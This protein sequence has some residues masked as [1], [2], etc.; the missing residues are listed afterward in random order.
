[1][2]ALS[3]PSEV[4]PLITSVI[5]RVIDTYSGFTSG[6]WLIVRQIL[7]MFFQG[8]RTKVSLFLTNGCQNTDG[9]F[10]LDTS[11]LPYG[12]E[13]PGIVRYYESNQIKS[14][15]HSTHINMTST[16]LSSLYDISSELGQSVYMKGQLCLFGSHQPVSD[17]IQDWRESLG[18]SVERAANRILPIL[19]GN[20]GNV[21]KRD[22]SAEKGK[23]KHENLNSS[24]K[25][26]MFEMDASDEKIG[27]QIIIV[28]QSNHYKNILDEFDDNKEDYYGQDDGHN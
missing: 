1:M 7:Y 11:V 21:A 27:I 16:P 19:A 12:T 28:D 13:N 10:L 25:L 26:D 22:L 3:D 2:K 9:S 17:D 8:R 14:V 24:M 20:H 5:E 23:I 15:V 18:D 6:G 4:A